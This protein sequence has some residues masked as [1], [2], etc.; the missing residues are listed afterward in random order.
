MIEYLTLQNPRDLDLFVAAHPRGHYMQTTAYGKSRSDYDWSC[1]VL[2]NDDGAIYASMALLSRHIR[3]TP[4]RIFY[5]PRGPVFS[6]QSEFEEI[7]TAARDFCRRQ[8]GYLLRMDPP[9]PE[10]DPIFPP[11]IRSMGF[12][13]DPL[14][15]YSAYQPRHVYQLPLLDISEES[16][17]A[18]F[19]PKTRY[20]IRLAIR[21]GVTVRNGTWR[22]LPIFHAMMR[23]TAARDGFPLRPI[24]FFDDFLT[25]MGPNASLLLAEKD[26]VVLAGAIQI[27]LGNK[28]WYAFGC[29]FNDG[30][31]NMSN[32]LLQWEMIRRAR[33]FGCSLFDLR[34]VMGLP[35]PQNPAHG[36]HRFKQGFG[37]RFVSYAGQMDLP[38]RPVWYYLIQAL[39]RFL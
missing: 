24:T 25:S 33:W 9:I 34:G 26:G 10:D 20:N 15:D 39:R 4:C 3:I 17:L 30:R 22:D 31:S 23:E 2:R 19:H 8:G 21:R 11:L 32:H 14:D 29:S 18:S 16:L 5:A 35:S 38:L 36:L 1:L 27:L 28:A 37:A 12:R 13:I 7:C 6:S